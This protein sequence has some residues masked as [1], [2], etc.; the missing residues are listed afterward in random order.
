MLEG[1]YEAQCLA[2][3]SAHVQI[4]DARV[5]Q[6]TGF[7]DDEGAPK[8]DCTVWRQYAIILRDLLRQI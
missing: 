5:T 2:G 1:L 3:I 8:A 4:I 6:Y 7:V